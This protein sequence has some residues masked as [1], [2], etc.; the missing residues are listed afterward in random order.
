ME[1][2]KTS[3][4]AVSIHRLLSELKIIDDRIVGA[5]NTAEPVGWKQEGKL[6]NGFHKIE[7]FAGNAKQHLIQ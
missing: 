1:D 4:G 3:N 2:Q 7:E 6:V 5:I